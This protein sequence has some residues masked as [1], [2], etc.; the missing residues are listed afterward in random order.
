MGRVANLGVISALMFSK[1]RLSLARVCG[2]LL[3]AI[4]H[5]KEV[6]AVQ[7]TS[8][9][10]DLMNLVLGGLSGRKDNR[11]LLTLVRSVKAMSRCVGR[12]NG[13]GTLGQGDD[14]ASG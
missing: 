9:I 11:Q 14:S 8:N 6:L 12:G 13:D 7:Q 1:S 5:S 3:P 2:N 4:H 10:L